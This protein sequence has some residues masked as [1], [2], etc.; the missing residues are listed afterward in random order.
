MNLLT[1]EYWNE[2]FRSCGKTCFRGRAPGAGGLRHCTPARA[3]DSRTVLT[4]T[5]AELDLSRQEAVERWLKSQQPEALFFAAAKVGGILAN[6]APIRP[7]SFT[8]TS[9]LRRTLSTP[10][11]WLASKSLVFL[12]SSASIRQKLAPQPISEDVL[13]TAPGAHKR[14]VR[15]RK[16]RRR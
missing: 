14:M 12:G 11:T 3:K 1:G 7:T 4:A 8:T 13:L 6:S 16:D 15:N 5:R 9:L 2:A 10:P